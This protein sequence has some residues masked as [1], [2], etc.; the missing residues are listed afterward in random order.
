MLCDLA[1]LGVE[2]RFILVAF[3]G[4]GQLSEAIGLTLRFGT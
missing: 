4:A 2:I 3:E 1:Q